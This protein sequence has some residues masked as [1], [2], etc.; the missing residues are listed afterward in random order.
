MDEPVGRHAASEAVTGIGWRYVLGQLRTAVQVDSL[1]AAVDL[2]ARA[3]AICGPDADQHLWTDLRRNRVIL[4]LQSQATFAVTARDVAL[5]RRISEAVAE[6]GRATVPDVG[7]RAVQVIE[8]AIDAMD[9]LSVRPFWKAIMG[10]V[11]EAGGPDPDVLVDPFGQSPAIWFQQMDA[12]RPQRNRIHID[13]SVPHDEAPRRL[14]AALTAAGRL[15][16][17]AYAPSFWV[18]ADPEGNE[19]CVTTWQ[20]R[21]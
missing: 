20:G 10:Y 15:V 14:E 6:L 11:D 13:I 8:I 9:I 12:P 4:A 5:A 19:A 3:V 21:G 7:G 16:S 17:D 2:A 18:L 1:A